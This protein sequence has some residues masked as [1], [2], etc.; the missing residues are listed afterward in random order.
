MGNTKKSH[1]S[2]RR[3]AAPGR[4]SGVPSIMQVQTYLGVGLPA[5]KFVLG[6]CF[7]VGRWKTT[8]R[9][10]VPQQRSDL[11]PLVPA[12][13]HPVC[14]VQH[15]RRWMRG[16]RVLRNVPPPQWAIG[17]PI[18]VVTST[19]QGR[20]TIRTLFLCWVKK[21]AEKDGQR[22][23]WSFRPGAGGPLFGPWPSQDPG[24]VLRGGVARRDIFSTRRGIL[25]PPQKNIAHYFHTRI[26]CPIY[27][28]LMGSSLHMQNKWHCKQN[29]LG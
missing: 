17:A 5:F 3:F 24:L 13:D 7:R 19:P 6:L 14:G 16:S 20:P 8:H 1:F 25:R 28:S 26:I 10:S 2:L 27:P 22:F 12:I 21:K 18:W 11:R 15:N 23:G 9:V 4:R 29:P